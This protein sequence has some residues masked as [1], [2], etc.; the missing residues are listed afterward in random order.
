MHY[1]QEIGLNYSNYGDKTFFMRIIKNE[2]LIQ[3]NARIGRIAMFGGLFVLAVG[4]YISFQ[5][6][7]QYIYS[8]GALLI[9]F[10]LSQVGIYFTNRWSR[11]PRPDQVLDQ[12]LK[13]LDDNYQINHY[14]SPV[15]HLLIGPCGVWILHPRT[16][17]GK[18]AYSNGRWRH[19]GGSLYLKI[20][21]QEGLGR[22]DLE[23]LNEEEKLH[24]YLK[25]NLKDDD[26]P[27]IHSALI[28]T[29][30]QVEISISEESTPPAETVQINKLK[31]LIRKYAKA[32]NLSI[33][34][35]KAL[36]LVFE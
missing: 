20:F 26:T 28:F 22:P 13:G 10:L 25:A 12:A 3:R 6:K 18:I 15:P 34:K 36:Q 35:A 17:K 33:D 14:S 32:K 21:A 2:R 27:Q 7:D 5:H 11:N 30:P 1:F 9:G 31:E 19:R 23:I 8:L 16:Q 24:R 29:H 4:M